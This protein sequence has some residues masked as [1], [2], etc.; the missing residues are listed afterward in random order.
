MTDRQRFPSDG[1]DCSRQM[2]NG[3]FLVQN[4]ILRLCGTVYLLTVVLDHGQQVGRV[5]HKKRVLSQTVQ[6]H[7]D[8]PY[9]ARGWRAGEKFRQSVMREYNEEKR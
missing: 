9:G 3:V 6:I 1:F 8:L 2:V 4:G 5:P 7:V